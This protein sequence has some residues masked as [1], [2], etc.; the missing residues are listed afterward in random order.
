[1]MRGNLQP[2]NRKAM[3]CSTVAAAVLCATAAFAPAHA[4][5]AAP[6]ADPSAL[7]FSGL[8]DTGVYANTNSGSVNPGHLFTDKHDKVVL[9]QAMLTAEKD[10]DPKAT[11]YDWGFKAQG[12]YGTDAR[13]THFIGLFDHNTNDRMQFDITEANLLAHTPW[14]TQGGIDIKVGAYSTP[15]GYEVIQASSNPL[16]SHSYIFNYGLPLK[17]TGAL[18]TTHVNDMLD[19][20]L[21]VD[22]GIN[23]TYTQRGQTNGR[24]S[25]I[26]GL[27]FNNLL[28]GKLTILALS[29]FGPTDAEARID[30]TNGNVKASHYG[31]YINDVVLTY[32]PDDLWTWVTEVNFTKDDLL[33]A[34]AFGLA[35]YGTYQ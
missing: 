9:N 21:G 34:R 32:K 10:L 22:S 11:G 5:D 20:W 26:A 12:F 16:Y 1:M 27:G 31:K 18:T 4:D 23:T 8:I 6:A 24:V 30:Q 35:Q 28:D 13:Y 2:N 7:K 14:L 33:S 29:H 3:L 15:I 19:V 17:H 25:G